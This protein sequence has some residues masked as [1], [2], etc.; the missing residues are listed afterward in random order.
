MSF[1]DPDFL[2]RFLP[3]FLLV[4]YLTPARLRI[5]PLIG[6]SV[7]FLA[8]G[9]PFSCLILFVLGAWNRLFGRAAANRDRTALVIGIT[10]DLAVLITAKTIRITAG[11]DCLPAGISFY[12]FRMIWY[13]ADCYRGRIKKQPLLSETVAF[14]FLFPVLPAGPILTYRDFE[15]ISTLGR[16]QADRPR[17]KELRDILVRIEN[18][19]LLFIPGLAAKVL[20]SD[21]LRSL[22]STL[23]G[24]GYESIS[25]PLA[26]LGIYTYSMELY[27]DFWGYSLMAAG[28]CVMTGLPA[29][30]N[31]R[32]PYA[33]GSVSEFYRRWHVT[34]GTFFKENVYIPL[35]GNRR[36][37]WTTV[38]NLF[39]V[40]L[41][42][43]LWH[44]FGLNY[45]V[46]AGLLFLMILAERGLRARAP[47]LYPVIGRIFVLA[48]IPL[49]WAVFAI[50][51]PERLL[52]YFG[53]LFP[54]AGTAGNVYDGDFVKYLTGYG[55]YLAL[56]LVFLV[57]NVYH[58][59]ERNRRKPFTAVLMAA[60]FAASLVSLVRAGDNPFLYLQF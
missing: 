55:I 56:A 9:D 15:R 24:I 30:E 42:T 34:L 16:A 3:V 57:P 29:V 40:W 44:G 26:W 58:C 59:F 27:Y 18:G 8:L 13:L 46:W 54:F 50:P 41:L 12:V 1:T 39:I 37:A 51:D 5:W 35:G 10:L 31:F 48:G 43:G 11:I 23:Y 22:W 38:R 4:F 45:L 7:L 6:G 53:R 14:F 36:G 33:A 28:L 25:T 60:L 21:H 52:T 20:L 49:T 47:R 19:L 2:F 32:H 17:R